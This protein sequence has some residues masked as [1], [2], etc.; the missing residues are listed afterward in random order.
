VARIDAGGIK[1]YASVRPRP[2]F[3][4]ADPKIISSAGMYHD[5]IRPT[6]N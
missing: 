4:R 1:K 2:I 6:V 3:R 5:E